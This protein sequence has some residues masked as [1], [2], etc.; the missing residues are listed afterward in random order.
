[1]A[2]VNGVMAIWDGAV[3]RQRNTQLDWDL[4]SHGDGRTMGM[5]MGTG[6][7]KDGNGLVTG[8]AASRDS[9]VMAAGMGAG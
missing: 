4:P 8:T 5:G 1:M 3:S 2:G 6:A 7:H 9:C